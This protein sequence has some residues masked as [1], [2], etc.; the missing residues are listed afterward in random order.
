MKSEKAKKFLRSKKIWS[1]YI[2]V[3]QYVIGPRNAKKAVEI[4]EAEMCER[5][6]EARKLTCA[7]RGKGEEVDD[8]G[9]CW[10]KNGENCSQRCNGMDSEGNTC[11]TVRQFIQQLDKQKQE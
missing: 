6:I 4:A 1:P 3:P 2:R 11:A 8:I 10:A 5:A 9:H 7:F